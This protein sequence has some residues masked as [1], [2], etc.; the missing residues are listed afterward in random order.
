MPPSRVRKVQE[1]RRSNIAVPHRNKS[2]YNRKIKH[3]N[4]ESE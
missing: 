3:R 4:R 2:K 1:L